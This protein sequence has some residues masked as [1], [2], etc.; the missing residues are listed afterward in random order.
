MENQGKGKW[1]KNTSLLIK[2]HKNSLAQDIYSKYCIF[3]DTDLLAGENEKKE[4]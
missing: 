3:R 2:Q 1:C 4:K